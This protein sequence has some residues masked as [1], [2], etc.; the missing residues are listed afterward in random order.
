MPDLAI[1][2]ACMIIAANILLHWL[3]HNVFPKFPSDTN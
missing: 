3:E 2:T 1:A